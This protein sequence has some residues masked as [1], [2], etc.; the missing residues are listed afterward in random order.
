M[1]PC[2]D[3]LLPRGFLFGALSM[4]LY[5]LSVLQNATTTSKVHPVLRIAVG[6]PVFLAIGLLLERYVVSRQQQQRRDWLK[7]MIRTQLVITC[8]NFLYTEENEELLYW[9]MHYI[10]YM[11]VVNVAFFCIKMVYEIL[12]PILLND[13]NTKLP[14]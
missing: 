11:F 7:G 8:T 10:P 14:S 4:G 9:S 2:D 5:C 3:Y 1:T 13:K 6:Y 12:Y